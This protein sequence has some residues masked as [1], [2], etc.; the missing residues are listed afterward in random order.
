MLDKKI[1]L[2][3]IGALAG[4]FQNYKI[5]A[6]FMYNYLNDLTNKEFMKAIN[7]IIKGMRELYPNTNLV[8]LIREK[9]RGDE[10]KVQLPYHKQFIGQIWMEER[11]QIE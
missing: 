7:E 8:A 1:Y 2:K 3:G 11:K 9:A 6:E 10:S 5:S 4:I